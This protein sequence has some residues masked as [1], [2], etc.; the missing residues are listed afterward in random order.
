MQRIAKTLNRR[1]FI[2][3]ASAVTAGT[4]FMPN[5]ITGA[6]AEENVLRVGLGHEEAMTAAF[7]EPFT[8]ETG[9]RVQPAAPSRE[10]SYTRFKVAV[11]TGNYDVDLSTAISLDTAALMLREGLIEEELGVS[12]PDV[13]KFPD[14]AKRDYWLGLLLVPYITAYLT[15]VSPDRLLTIEDFWD[16][17][18]VPA[19]RGLRRRPNENIEFA[20][21]A[22][23]VAPADIYQML[24]SEEGWARAYAKLDEIKPHIAVWW[25]DDSTT[26]QLLL[27]REVEFNPTYSHRA[28]LL[29]RD[30]VDLT[31]NYDR[32]FYNVAGFVIPKGNPRADLAREFI[33]FAIQGE[34][35]AEYIRRM[36]VGPFNPDALDH[37]DADYASQLPTHP[38]NFG[39]LALLDPDFWA[40]NREE[41]DERFNEWL[42]T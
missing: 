36:P 35:Y 24:S 28:L 19:R 13:D 16:V 2:R 17:E 9:I 20:L 3:R 11:E 8:R 7:I 4:L 15:D 23:G 31:I 30:G 6:Q 32:G 40:A 21:R 42:L 1:T 27:S 29:R 10:N 39:K 38:D 34:H 14:V 37:L 33:S 25:G 12:G 26:P 41:A 5:I 22:D 18:G